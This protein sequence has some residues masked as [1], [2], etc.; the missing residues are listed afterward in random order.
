MTWPKMILAASAALFCL[1]LTQAQDRSAPVAPRVLP[2]SSTDSPTDSGNLSPISETPAPPSV[3]PT[4]LPPTNPFA[5][6]G[7]GAFGGIR[8]GSGGP[9]YSATWYPSRSVS[10]QSTDLALF[11]QNLSLAAPLWKDNGD[12]LML[13]GGIQESHFTTS[14][15]LPDTRRAFPSD[16]WNIN[17]GLNYLHHFDNG[18]T[19]GLMFESFVRG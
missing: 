14:A 9:G 7:M 3:L 19:G 11:R 8:G 18:W 13:T 6:G 12:A 5:D 16:L 1:G 2:V 15:V 17:L 10:G 4:T